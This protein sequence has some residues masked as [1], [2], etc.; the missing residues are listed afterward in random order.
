LLAKKFFLRI[1]NLQTL[2][3]RLL[4]GFEALHFSQAFQ[5]YFSGYQELERIKKNYG[6]LI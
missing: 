5:N 2:F 1:W 3:K 6:I 4:D